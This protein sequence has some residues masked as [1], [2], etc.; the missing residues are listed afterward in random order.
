MWLRLTIWILILVFNT[1]HSFLP[2]RLQANKWIRIV[3]MVVASFILLRYAYQEIDTVRTRSYAY[4]SS[5][6][7]IIKSN[8][9]SWK[10]T[11][12]VPSEE[13]IYYIID[14]RGDGSEVTV[15]PDGFTCEPN[16]RGV[17]AGVCIQFDCVPSK[18]SGFRIDVKR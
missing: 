6:G 12:V 11:H 1:V 8:N 18:A 4:V 2:N 10:I 7:Q 17:E 14:K 9:F 16:V 3:A 5:D 13:S 15:T